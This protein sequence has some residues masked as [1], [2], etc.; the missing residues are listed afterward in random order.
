M[1][2]I[3]LTAAR[4]AA[5]YVFTRGRHRAK[6]ILEYEMPTIPNLSLIHI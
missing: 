1:N 6:A 2:I 5:I 3:D 4:S